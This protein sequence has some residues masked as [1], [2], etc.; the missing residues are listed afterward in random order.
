MAGS[1]PGAIAQPM[2]TGDPIADIQNLASMKPGAKVTV[3]QLNV[4]AQMAADIIF[5]TQIG[6]PRNQL[7][8]MIKS[9]NPDLHAIVSSMVDEIERQASQRGLDMARQGQ[10]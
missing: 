9:T 1:V 4:D 7:Y 8:S 2:Q 5:R 3:E 6:A 10:I